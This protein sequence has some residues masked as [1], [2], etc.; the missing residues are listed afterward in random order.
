MK[1]VDS[2]AMPEG[3]TLYDLIQTGITHTHAFVGVL[4]WLRK[5]LS[6]VKDIPV[7]IAIDQVRLKNAVTLSIFL[8]QSSY[9]LDNHMMHKYF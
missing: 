4:V 6:L 3:S 2:M 5:E 9:Y 1:G 8:F 7:L